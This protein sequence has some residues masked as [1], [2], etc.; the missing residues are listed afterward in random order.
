MSTH[1]VSSFCILASGLAEVEPSDGLVLVAAALA[2][3]P[4]PPRSGLAMRPKLS[5]EDDAAFC[6]NGLECEYG[7][8]AAENGMSDRTACLLKPLLHRL[9]LCFELLVLSSKPAVSVLEERLQV[10]YPLVPCQQ[11][12]LRDP[13]FL[14]ERG[15]L[16]DELSRRMH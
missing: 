3:E 12:A 13:R 9:Q 11:F 2:A 6:A 8:Q 14:L 1:P 5:G 7:T 15:V 16:V 4:P 10:L